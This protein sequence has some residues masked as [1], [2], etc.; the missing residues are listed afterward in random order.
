MLY[1]VLLSV[2]KRLE[3]QPAFNG[4][5]TPEIVAVKNESCV[6]VNASGLYAVFSQISFRFG[7]GQNDTEYTSAHKLI[8]K[9]KAEDYMESILTK[10]IIFVLQNRTEAVFE[11]SNLSAFPEIN[12]DDKICVVIPENQ[13]RLIYKST[14]DNYLTVLKL[15]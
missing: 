13:E 3:W 1:I 4:R 9:A 14:I 15:D 8:L 2:E 10:R 11:P 6:M 5:T 12:T 7:S